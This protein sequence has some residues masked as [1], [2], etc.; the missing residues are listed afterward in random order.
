MSLH[1]RRFGEQL[2][3]FLEELANEFGLPDDKDHAFH[4][5]RTFFHVL[6]NR[7]RVQ[8]S[9]DIMD[10]L[11]TYLRAVYVDGWHVRDGNTA[12]ID[13]NEFEADMLTEYGTGASRD[14]LPRD[15]IIIAAKD[16]FRVLGRHLGEYERIEMYNELPV[17]VRPLW[18]ETVLV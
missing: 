8:E 2:G 18:M 13:L 6:R 16:L 9:F 17:A 11:P 3:E 7:L 4:V 1:Y 12:L 14:F 5:L 15:R 10:L